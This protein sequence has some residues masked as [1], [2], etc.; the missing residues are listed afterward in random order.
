MAKGKRGKK[1]GKPG[2]TAI[3]VEIFPMEPPD[4]LDKPKPP[5][6]KTQG[7][8]GSRGPPP[9]DP[10]PKPKPDPTGTL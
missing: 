8:G 10:A 7:Q 5:D 4:C 3:D 6:G 2:E 9:I 1:K